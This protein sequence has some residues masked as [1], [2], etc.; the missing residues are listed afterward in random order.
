MEM[1]ALSARLPEES[2]ER[3]SLKEIIGDAGN[4]LREARRSIAGLRGASSGLAASIEQA[5]TQ[6]VQTQDVHLELHLASTVKPLSTETEYNLLRVA[7]EALTNALK[8]SAATNVEITL[9]S[10]ADEVRLIVRDNGVGF[11]EPEANLE[12]LGHYGLLGMRERARQIGAKFNVQSSVGHGTTV[13][14]VLPTRHSFADL[15]T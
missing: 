10:T 12:T 7:Q 15:P 2:S 3:E 9:Q 4:C 14:V 13:C 11:A 1:Q 6:L 5:A 8:H